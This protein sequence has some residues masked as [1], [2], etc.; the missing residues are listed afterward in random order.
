MKICDKIEAIKNQ[1]DSPT[2]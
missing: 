2:N 1:V